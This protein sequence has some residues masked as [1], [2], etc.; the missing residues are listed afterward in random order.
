M[1]P[2][3]SPSR[4]G[5]RAAP[6]PR[7]RNDALRIGS[8][9][10]FLGLAALG[11]QNR[12]S[13]TVSVGAR[14]ASSAASVGQGQP[15]A[16]SSSG[17]LS[18]ADFGHPL[19]DG[20]VYVDDS[21]GRDGTYP[22]VAVIVPPAEAPR[23]YLDGHGKTAGYWMPTVDEV[24][25]TFEVVRA[26]TWPDHPNIGRQLHAYRYQVVG[27]VLGGKHALYF[28]AFCQASGDWQTKLVAVKDGGDCYFQ[29]TMDPATRAEVKLTVNGEG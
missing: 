8:V 9:A 6:P 23:F 7:R 19:A 10:T 13:S 3:I 16:S 17:A 25:T 20:F 24:M 22:F 26:R 29:L 4:H 18:Y 15:A 27:I 12:P 2:H 21:I 14:T 11:C 28:N 1:I 5:R